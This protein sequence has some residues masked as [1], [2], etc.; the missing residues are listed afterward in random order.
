MNVSSVVIKTKVGKSQL[1]I[2]TLNALE[3]CEVYFHENE[4]IVVVIEGESTDEEIRKLKQIEKLGDV[5]SVGVVFAYSEDE[6]E[7]ERDKIE[8]AAATPEWLNNE[9]IKAED[10]KYKGDL[11]KKV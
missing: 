9:N 5:L 4:K 7:Q 6:L 10:I 11:R 8:M 1:I 3:L 2:N